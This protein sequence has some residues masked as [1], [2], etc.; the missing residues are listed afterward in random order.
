[1][2]KYLLLCILFASTLALGPTPAIAQDSS[3]APCSSFQKLPDGNWKV[4]RPV[5][6]E[7]ATSSVMLGAGM[8]I[9]PGTNAVGV[10]LYY[11]LQK[12]CK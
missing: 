7:H 9:G 10:N 4:L 5:K 1:M 6:I 11:A 12:N 2:M 8:T 3:K